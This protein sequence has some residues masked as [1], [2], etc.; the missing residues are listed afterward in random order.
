MFRT[1]TQKSPCREGRSSTHSSRRQVTSKGGGDGAFAQGCNLE[2]SMCVYSRKLLIHDIDKDRS[3]SSCR[4]CGAY[5]HVCRRDPASPRVDLAALA[6]AD[7]RRPAEVRARRHACAER[8][9]DGDHAAIAQAQVGGAASARAWT[10]ANSRSEAR[11]GE[12]RG[13]AGWGE[14][15]FQQAGSLW[16]ARP[17][18]VV[19]FCCAVPPPTVASGPAAGRDGAGVPVSPTV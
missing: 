9:A 2:C 1:E 3:V 17:L 18:S 12:E 10:T 8:V 4:C 13:R 6:E 11:R 15:R 19:L 5:S 16:R 7:G 14:W